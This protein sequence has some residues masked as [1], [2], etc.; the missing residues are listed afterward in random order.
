MILLTE[1]GSVSDHM[2]LKIVGED[3]RECCYKIIDDLH[4]WSLVEFF[5]PSR[6]YIQLDAGIADYI[7]RAGYKLLPRFSER[8]E[9]R[10]KEYLSAPETP[11]FETADLSDYLYGIQVAIKMDSMIVNVSSHR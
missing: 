10:T 8:L 7:D 11:S 9:Q 3:Y 4:Y 1:V 2:L 5:G 6:E